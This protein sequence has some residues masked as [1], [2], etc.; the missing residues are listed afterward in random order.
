MATIHLDEQT[1]HRVRPLDVAAPDAA[2]NLRDELDTLRRVI[3]GLTNL[4]GDGPTEPDNAIAQDIVR[5]YARLAMI[6][7]HLTDLEVA[8]KHHQEG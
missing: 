6:E 8:V 2:L 4:L 5:V 7:H 3:D 1:G